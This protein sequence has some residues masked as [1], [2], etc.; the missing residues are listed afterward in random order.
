M[1]GSSYVGWDRAH[2]HSG[3]SHSDD[4]SSAFLG[5]AQNNI[6]TIHGQVKHSARE[7]RI[8]EHLGLPREYGKIPHPDVA[9]TE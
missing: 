9:I 1:N 3:V 8:T 5:P 6:S 7:R 4:V 2:R